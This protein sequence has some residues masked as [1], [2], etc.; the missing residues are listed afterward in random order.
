M[1]RAGHDDGALGRLP[2][3]SERAGRVVVACRCC[4]QQDGLKATAT[5]KAVVMGSGGF[6]ESGLLYHS[7]TSFLF[8]THLYSIPGG[9]W[10]RGP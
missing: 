2:E 5:V 4:L 6:L 10:D 8:I 3:R 9:E 7:G 1:S